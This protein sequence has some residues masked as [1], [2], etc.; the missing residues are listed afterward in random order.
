MNQFDRRQH[1]VGAGT[2]PACAGSVDRV[3]RTVLHRSAALSVC[4]IISAVPARGQTVMSDSI[5]PWLM[6]VPGSPAERYVRSLEVGGLRPKRSVAVRDGFEQWVGIE[7]SGPSES[8]PWGGVYRSM[9]SGSTRWGL[10]PARAMTAFNSGF[11]Y[12]RGEGPVWYGRGFTHAVEA[13]VHVRWGP[14]RAVLNPLWFRAENESFELAQTRSGG[15]DYVFQSP[16]QTAGRL[17]MPQRFGFGAYQ[18]LALGSS[19][20][21]LD[22]T[23]VSLGLSSAPQKWGPG[24]LHPMVLGDAAGGVPHLFVGTQRPIPALIGR[25]SARYVAAR[26]RQSQWSVGDGL[27]RERVLNGFVIA[28]QPRGLSGL[29]LGVT[30]LFHSPWPGEGAEANMTTLIL[31]P[32]EGLIKSGLSGVNR[33]I[34]DQFASAFF[35][36]MPVRGSFEV[37]G[38]FARVDHSWDARVAFL[39]PDDIAGYTLGFRKVWISDPQ[40]M[41]A[42]RGESIVSGSTHRER[43][44]ARLQLAERAFVFYSGVR[45]LGGLTHRGLIL[46]TTAGAYGNAQSLGLDRYSPVGRWTLELDRTV[47]RDETLGI[48]PHESVGPDVL[49]A[50]TGEFSR[51]VGTWDLEFS[52]SWLLNLNRYL[53]RDASSVRF[54]LIVSRRFGRPPL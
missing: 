31:R 20:L 6:P 15:G 53:V 30:R 52:S 38:E 45:G 4:V 27:A 11:P 3:L 49:Y 16:L 1:G 9:P 13:G 51:F 36:W 48:A 17:D 29:E 10:L 24:D 14:L 35:R 54:R 12:Q 22:V 23:G 46:S 26:T 47:V 43:G 41:T 21:R 44:G 7:G 25:L 19:A 50:F 32:F 34:D 37:F 33:R 28:L 39:E 18:G 40:H 8:G 42:L 5:R 2:T